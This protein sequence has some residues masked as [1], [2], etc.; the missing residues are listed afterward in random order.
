MREAGL[1]DRVEIRLQD[2]R[3]TDDGPFDKI[4]SIGMFEHVGAANLAAYLDAR[5]RC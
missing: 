3:E 1:Q 5:R 4:A 2:Y